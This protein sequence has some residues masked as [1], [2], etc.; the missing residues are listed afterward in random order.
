LDTGHV[1]DFGPGPISDAQPSDRDDP[2][3]SLVGA[4]PLGSVCGTGVVPIAGPPRPPVRIGG[5]IKEPRLIEGR[6]PL[7]PPIAQA[8]GVTGR[9]VLEAHVG[10]DG[11]VREVRITEGGTLF[12]EA[13]LA[14]VRSRRYEPL[15]LNGIPTDFLLTI[16]VTF[17]SRR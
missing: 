8:A 13:A 17:N 4:C 10:P 7:Y 5:V 16:T 9:V 1:L 3:G 11:R 12:D 6:A 14:S 2:T 15:L